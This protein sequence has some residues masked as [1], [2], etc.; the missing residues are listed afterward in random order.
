M[1]KSSFVV[2]L[3]VGLSVVATTCMAQ[4]SGG[5]EGHRH[6]DGQCAGGEPGNGEEKLDLDS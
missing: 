4:D 2:G 3:A 5:N 1:W 6:K